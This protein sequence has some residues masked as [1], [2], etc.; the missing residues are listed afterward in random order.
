M[1]QGLTR[2]IKE[3][4]ILK[5]FLGILMISFAIWGVGDSINPAVDPNVAIKVDQVEVRTE[6]LQRRFTAEVNQLRQAIGTDFTAK[7]AADL[8]IMDNIVA[9]LSER[10]TLDMGR[11]HHGFD[12][13]R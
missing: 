6:E 10:A 13:S 1:I 11:S 8:G 2:A 9:Q 5:G 4:W 3:S 7:D 12:N